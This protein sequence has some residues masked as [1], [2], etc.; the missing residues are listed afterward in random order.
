MAGNKKISEL[1]TI[2]T[3]DATAFFPIVDPTELAPV[4]QNKKV[5]VSQLDAR[6]IS[7]TQYTI[8]FDAA[9]AAKTS[10]N[11]SEGAVNKYYTDV[12]VEANAEVLANTTARHA[13]LSL[14]PD[15]VNVTLDDVN[16]I[17][18]AKDASNLNGGV[19]SAEDWVNFHS[20]Q[21]RLPPANEFSD[22]LLSTADWQLF[23]NKVTKSPQDQDEVA[24]TNIQQ[25]QGIPVSIPNLIVDPNTTFSFTIFM[26]VLIET[27]LGADLYKNLWL[28]G[29]NTTDSGIVM[30]APVEQDSDSFGN[31][32]NFHFGIN[33][34]TGQINYTSGSYSNFSSG[35]LRYRVFTTSN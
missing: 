20:K 3:I 10:D 23:N 12:R 13:P 2:A 35:E 8:L 6:Y 26:S 33:P 5:T 19:I 29:V 34:I 30:M 1:A 18:E 27:S 31:L 24:L 4:D 25:N 9:L 14:S 22:G 21:D 32:N 15:T 17:I 11:I 7:V 16:Q 28:K